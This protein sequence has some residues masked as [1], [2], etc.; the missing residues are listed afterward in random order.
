MAYAGVDDVVERW[1]K[2]EDDLEEEIVAL[3]E[4]RLGDVER[5]I[6]RRIPDLADRTQASADFLADV[7]QVEA[8][9]VLRLAR[10]PDG[11][12]SETDGNYTYML[13]SDL[14]SGKLEIPAEEWETLGIRRSR[15]AILVPTNL[16]AT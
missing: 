10:N 7:I 1:G 4:V 6:R 3:I 8:D 16:P 2:R 15:M 11:Y 14:S 5:M 13:R 12:Q 9:A